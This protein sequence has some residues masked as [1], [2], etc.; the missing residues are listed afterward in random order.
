MNA[1][2]RK[3]LVVELG[4]LGD[5]VH[6]LPALWLVRQRW[7][8]AG[9]HVLVNAHV[10]GLFRLAPWVD[11]VWA[12]A[13]PPQGKLAALRRWMRTLRGERFDVVIDTKSSDRSSL[14][15]WSTRAPRRIGRRPADGG[16]LGWRLLFH[17][18][19]DVPYYTEPMYWQKWRAVRQA[20]FGG[21][22]ARPEFHI[23]VDAQLRRAAGI[24]QDD[25]QRYIHVS[26]CTT[27]DARELPAAQLAELLARLRAAFPQL[28]LVLSCANNAREQ[29]K[30][31]D[32][33]PR[34]AEAPWKVFS[35][36]LDIPALAAVIETAALNLSGDTGS[37]HLAM[38]TRTPALAWFRHHRG[39]KEWIAEGAQYRTLIAPDEGP[40]D[41]IHGL[42]TAALSAAAAEILKAKHG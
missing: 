42:D 8:Q 7:P 5:N 29:S 18:V 9:L 28:R 11:R 4:G 14:L 15:A 34:L 3:V 6:L 37:L 41:A 10:A 31:A 16:P 22:A 35:G 26:P 38:L 36:T 39:E 33:V 27:A 12:Y 24:V 19:V 30:L 13:K 17:E 20:G 32:L 40:R 1:E 21:E 2:V 25:E 23:A